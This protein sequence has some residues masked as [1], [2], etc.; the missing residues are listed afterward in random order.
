M[1]ET[2]TKT[3]LTQDAFDRLNDELE[4]LM[5]PARLEIVKRIEA[6]REELSLIHI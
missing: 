4:E 6:A 5:G 1:A 2:P 3:W